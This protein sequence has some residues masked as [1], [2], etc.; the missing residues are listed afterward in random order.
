MGRSLDLM[1]AEAEGLNYQ[2]IPGNL[3][4]EY[5]QRNP[6]KVQQAVADEEQRLLNLMTERAN[7]AEQR[8]FKKMGVDPVKAKAAEQHQEQQRLQQQQEGLE[9][10]KRIEAMQSRNRRPY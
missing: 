5:Q 6:T 7:E 3:K 2:Q 8:K 10:Q 9:S 1:A 4:A